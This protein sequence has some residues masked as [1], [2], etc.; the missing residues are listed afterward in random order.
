MILV[1]CMY[2]HVSMIFFL[3]N[4]AHAKSLSKLTMYA[5][6]W[7]YEVYLESVSVDVLRLNMETNLPVNT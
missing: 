6:A 5:A 1:L 4:I 7:E 3:E 2:V